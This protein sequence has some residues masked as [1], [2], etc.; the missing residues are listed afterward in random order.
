MYW[1]HSH[2]IYKYLPF[3]QDTVNIW[4]TFIGQFGKLNVKFF[5]LGT[6][7]LHLYM[8]KIGFHF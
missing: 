5:I 4:P 7:D 1:I 3:T 8:Y 6:N 2:G